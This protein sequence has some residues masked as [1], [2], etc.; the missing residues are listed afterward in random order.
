MIQQNDNRPTESLGNL[1]RQ[2]REKSNIDLKTVNEKTKIPL[3]TLTAMEED[4]YEALPAKAFAH[5]FYAI[6]AKF[7]G[8]DIDY[9][10]KQLNDKLSGKPEKQ[11]PVPTKLHS[12]IKSMA[13][14][15]SIGLG[16]ALG[17]ALVILVVAA[18]LISLSLD[19]NPASYLSKKI[20]SKNQVL[21]HEQMK[22]E[23]EKEREENNLYH[24]QAYFPSITKITVTK[25]E[26]PPENFLFQTGDTRSWVAQ[27]NITFI[28]P[29]D[30][31]VRLTVNGLI[32]S[33]PEPQYG[34]I[35]VKIP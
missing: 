5:G 9:I 3:K 11:T 17:F 20:R 4:D 31:K 12:Q 29:K 18:T 25:D 32:R 8:L 34:V 6:Y 7:L 24:V 2:Q 1:L 14:Q 16:T 15:P 13:V 27:K 22:R 10:V 19:L 30:S 23:G 35:T 26:Q 28:L 21:S 33:L